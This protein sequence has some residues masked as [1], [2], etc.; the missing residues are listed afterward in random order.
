METSNTHLAS[1]VQKLEVEHALLAH[2][3]D[4]VIGGLPFSAN[5]DTK[6]AAFAVI[7]TILPEFPLNEIQAVRGLTSKESLTSASTDS[8]TTQAHISAIPA[9][10]VQPNLRLVLPLREL[11]IWIQIVLA[12]QRIVNPRESM[13]H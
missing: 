4:V 2:A 11:L 3:A 12:Q 13:L 9:T 5:C 1:H 8:T 10:T 7:K 6:L